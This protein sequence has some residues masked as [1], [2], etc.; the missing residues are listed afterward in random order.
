[1]KVEITRKWVDEMKA[2]K[3]DYQYDEIKGGDHILSITA[4]PEM[5]GE[6]FDFFDRHVKK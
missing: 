2:L 1:M 4:N 3:M 6:V 5:I